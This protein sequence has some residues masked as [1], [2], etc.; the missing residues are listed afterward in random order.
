MRHKIR[1]NFDGCTLNWKWKMLKEKIA[2][3]Y[4]ICYAF[5]YVMPLNGKANKKEQMLTNTDY[6]N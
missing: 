2:I 1:L 3:V 6:N 5:L 4:F